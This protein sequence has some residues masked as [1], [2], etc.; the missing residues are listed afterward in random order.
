M[1]DRKAITLEYGRRQ[2]RRL[3]FLID[4]VFGIAIV[5]MLL[6]L[7][8]PEDGMKVHDF[9][10]LFKDRT[11][12]MVM[13]VIGLVWIIIFWIQN[14]RVFGT[15]ETT[16]TRH[17]VI[18]MAQLCATMLFIY[19]VRL[20]VEFDGQRGAMLFESTAAV[21][22]GALAIAGW[23]YASKNHRL[24]ADALTDSDVRRMT[25]SLLTEPIA[26]VLTIG[27]AFFGPL[28]WTAS[29]FVFGFLVKKSVKRWEARVQLD[30]AQ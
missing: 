19:A 23:L 26:A 6:L 8:R 24:I 20:G 15:L 10:E 25:A 4:V 30:E 16:D 14:N 18:S 11:G 5:R 29:W 27:A 3:E 7:P 21:L 2:L 22:M 13:V 28:A 9:T 12:A 1:P 17:T